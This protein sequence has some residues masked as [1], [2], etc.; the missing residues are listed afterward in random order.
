MKRQKPALTRPPVTDKAAR[1]SIGGEMES[2]KNQSVD[3]DKSVPKQ[4]DNAVAGKPA[5]SPSSSP[6]APEL[7]PGAGE[8][9]SR[10]ADV[11]P[12]AADGRPQPT[13]TTE[14]VE[15]ARAS[16]DRAESTKPAADKQLQAAPGD[17]ATKD[18]QPSAAEAASKTSAGAKDDAAAR[19]SGDGKKDTVMKPAGENGG[20][21]PPPKAPVEQRPSKSGRV[22]LVLSLVALIAVAVLGWQV[23]E[24]RQGAGE[25]R[26]EV[27]QRLSG[28]ETATAEVRALVRQNNEGL[29]ALQG[30]FGALESQ[31]GAME[32]QAATLELLYRESSRSRGDQVLA[33]LEQAITIAGQQ[34]QLAGNFE[35]ALIAL[36]GAE[37]RLAA[38]EFGHLQP[39]R[40][41]LVRD[42][43]ALKAHPQVDV[44]GIALRLELVL[45]RIDSLPLA[46]EV[47]L[48]ELAAEREAEVERA[49]EEEDA[50]GRTLGFARALGADI[51]GEVKGMV[52]LERLDNAD[53]VLLGP[54]QSNY[55]RENIKIRLLTARLALL[56]RDGR[57]YVTDLERA[58]DWLERYFDGGSDQ[59]RRTLD[60]LGELVATPIRA[61]LPTLT[62]TFAALRVLQARGAAVEPPASAEPGADEA[63]R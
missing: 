2:P 13:R 61:E 9:A 25:I 44:S 14:P 11:K 58:R 23:Y 33:E 8:A 1:T 19:A 49:R 35:A 42:I 24:L 41:A 48:A 16:S 5:T 34:L 7:R 30:R 60:E 29:S 31:V 36:Q 51:W 20:G 21:K 62:D 40:R 28:G 59:V 37:A 57:T 17:K 22:A 27:A 63:A 50:L 54:E 4:E 52:R 43:E 6:A 18:A 55:L 47:R 26:Q 53:P 15:P 56:A 39:L 12:A 10:G 46:F 3:A 38:P 32:G 45:E